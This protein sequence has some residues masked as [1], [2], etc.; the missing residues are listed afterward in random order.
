VSIAAGIGAV[1]E[2]AGAALLEGG[3]GPSGHFH[4][5]KSFLMLVP[6]MS[7]FLGMLFG[8]RY[9]TS[10]TMLD[11]VLR[12]AGEEGLTPGQMRY[13]KLVRNGVL[14][15]VFL[16]CGTLFLYL[17]AGI[18]G[19]DKSRW[20][21]VIACCGHFVMSGALLAAAVA[22]QRAGVVRPWLRSLVGFLG[23]AGV[24]GAPLSAVFLDPDLMLSGS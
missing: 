9:H 7:V 20:L 15:G 6:L 21:L 12:E 8:M 5:Y 16:F 10:Y 13:L 11:P 23:V 24:V 4:F 2:R 1:I 3:D 19:A 18:G 17:A 22:D 14:G